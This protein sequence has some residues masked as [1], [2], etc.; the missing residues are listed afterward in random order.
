MKK[1]YIISG[2]QWQQRRAW[3]TGSCT[4]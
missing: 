1:Q 4:A 3:R 2:K